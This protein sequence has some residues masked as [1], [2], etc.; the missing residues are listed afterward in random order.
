[1]DAQDII[2]SGILELYA[3][4][5]TTPEENL[6]VQ[7]YLQQYPEVAAELAAIEASI[8]SY[9]GGME[10]KPDAAVKEKIFTQINKDD[11]SSAKVIPLNTASAKPVSVNSFWK[12]VAAAA[13][14]L[15]LASGVLNLVFY[16]KNT[17]INDELQQSR[18]T[19]SELEAKNKEMDGYLE[20][21]RSKYSTPVSVAGLKEPAAGAKVF[22]MKN[23]GEVYVDPSN[24]PAAPQGKQYELW[25]I[26][27]GKPVNAGIII[28]TKQGNR[29]QIQKMKSFG[30]VQAF[31]V[32]VEKENPLPAAAPTEVYA[33]GKM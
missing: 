1:M 32:S 29:Y 12:N 4:G 30:A 33:M 24:L 14:L 28:T 18:A 3:A 17:Q 19:A 22:W 10:L 25:A 20:M 27:D 9:A 11:D 2:L 13:I 7:Q 15:L 23:S 31:A 5:L 16:N 21:V 8:E 26:V 6:Q